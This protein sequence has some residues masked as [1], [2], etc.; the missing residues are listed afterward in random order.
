M[1]AVPTSYTKLTTGWAEAIRDAFVVLLPLTLFG[2]CA[3][4][5]AQ[6]PFPAVR[7]WLDAGLGPGW[8]AV[9]DDIRR[10]TWGVFGLALAVV[11]AA[12]L[13]QRAPRQALVE[14]LPAVWVAISALLNFM[15]LHGAAGPSLGSASLLAG[16]AV[17]LSTPTLLRRLADWRLLRRF[18]T[19]YDSAPAFFHAAR[20]TL[21]VIVLGLGFKAAAELLRRLP[22]SAAGWPELLQRELGPRLDADWLLTPL[23]MLLH[24]LLWFF[25]V[26]GGTVIQSSFG[27]W[28]TYSPDPLMHDRVLMP[29]VVSF[30]QLGGAGATLGL[31]V[32]MTI[33]ARDGP[34]RRLAQ[35][36]WLPAL[37]NV[38]ELLLFGLPLVLNRRFLLPFVLVPLL[39]TLPPLVALH[40]GWL[41]LLPVRVP[42]TTPVLLSGWWLTGS[43][44][45]VAL[46]LFGLLVS[47]L[48]Y[49]PFVRRFEAE[50]QA[51]R[52]A[53][54]RGAGAAILAGA[55]LGR[56]DHVGVIARGLLHDLERAIG[57]PSLWL[58]YQP[59]HGL[60]GR[61][62]GVEALLRWSH[63]SYGPV[64]TDVVIALAERGGLIARLGEWVLD[65]A[66]ARKADW[67]TRGLGALTM[68]VNVSPLQLGEPGLAPAVAR[69]LQRHAL[70]P[71]DV[72]LEITES[73]GIPAG[74]AADRN[75]AALD[76]LGVRLAMD[77]F[78][79][80][81]ASLLHLKRFRVAAIKVD[82]S[83]SRDVLSH[84]VSADIIRAITTLGHSRG[85]RVI[86]E[87]V[88]TSEQRECLAALGC[89]VFQG[90]LYSRALPAGECLAYL[91][92]A[93]S[94][95]AAEVPAVPEVPA[96]LR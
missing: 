23:L 40:A 92:Q 22:L 34:T 69:V 15:L 57:T 39:L 67:N 30:V 27:A 6:L 36:S 75:L 17:G 60:D 1:P 31:L 52:L 53:E 21:P 14:P 84:P 61:P 63:P 25:G 91:V 66:C 43:W 37:F 8:A 3:T 59:Q 62:V 78:G 76:A 9:A 79:M 18:A 86:A 45:G 56:A 65:E 87:F 83:L 41:T 89:D 85:A 90:Y 50:R 73:H 82:G 32:A 51:R 93:G 4:V 20:L 42:W 48:V 72:E 68:S 71:G 38:N 2:V 46:Q 19:G 94:P 95:A 24:Q 54:F 77:D 35:L 49:L 47:T 28:L 55:A 88:E 44:V 33:V 11:L 10:S 81:H 96:V 16:I 5:V 64:R 26:H 74:E 58:A 12:M 13:A 70:K 80:G 29:L 7:S